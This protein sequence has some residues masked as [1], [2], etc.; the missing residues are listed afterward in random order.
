M[1]NGFTLIE[2]VIAIAISSL[3]GVLLFN[4]FDQSSRL[5]TRVDSIVAADINIVTFYDRFEKDVMGAFIPIIGDLN[6]AKKVL[7]Q[8]EGEMRA[9]EVKKQEAKEEGTHV[10]PLE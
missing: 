4:V 6:R 9:H 8:H 1:R 2:L 7:E 10:K 3:I 5:L